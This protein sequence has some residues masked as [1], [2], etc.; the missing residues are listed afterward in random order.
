MDPKSTVENS[1]AWRLWHSLNFLFG[2]VVFFIG[3]AI[4]FPHVNRIIP[5]SAISGW[6]YTLGSF[7]F[8]L[9]D[10]TECLHFVHR[11]CRFIWYA[12][13]FFLSVTGSAI[14]LIGSICFLPQV[15]RN[16]LG[17][18]YFIVGSIIIMISQIWKLC[19]TFCQPKKSCK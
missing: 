7:T 8:L 19:R 2:G 17:L 16:D 13:N 11:D 6:C 4:L 15:N 10:I 3:S 14:Y 18:D 1:L 9:A 12:L 5:A